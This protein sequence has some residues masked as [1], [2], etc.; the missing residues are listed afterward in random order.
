[1]GDFA[2]QGLADLPLLSRDDCKRCTIEG[3]KFERESSALVVPMDNCTQVSR[4]K[5]VQR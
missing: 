2:G 5:A 1:M 3:D 4:R